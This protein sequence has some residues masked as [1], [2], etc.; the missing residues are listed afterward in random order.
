M[1][2]RF[3]SISIDRLEGANKINVV[4]IIC[5][6]VQLCMVQ[7]LFPEALL[8]EKKS[9]ASRSSRF[10]S[11]ERSS[12]RNPAQPTANAPTSDAVFVIDIPPPSSL[13]FGRAVNAD[14]P[15]QKRARQPAFSN[16]WRV[17]TCVNDFAETP[18]PKSR[19]VLKS[20]NVFTSRMV[21]LIRMLWL[22]GLDKILAKFKLDS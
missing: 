2:Y 5:F 3:D 16:I 15:A 18:C 19:P 6:L 22:S 12:D 4:Q 1:D 11:I 17:R 21:K 20:W 13:L 7:Y 9:R 10:L 8:F 14:N